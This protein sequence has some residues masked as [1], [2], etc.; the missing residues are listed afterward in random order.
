V[1]IVVT[2]LVVARLQVRGN[3][4]D[5]VW[6][7]DGKV[8]LA[9]AQQH[10]L[11]SMYYLYAGYLQTVSRALALAGQA[12]LPLHDYATYTVLA[13]ALVVGA[14]AAFVYV[15]AASVLG[16]A[17]WAALP[18]LGMALTPALAIASL[19][20][21]TD[22]QWY[23]IFAAFWAML[24]PAGTTRPYAAT[25][26]AGLAALTS[27]IAVLVAPAAVVA[28]G[29]KDALRSW[30]LRA[31][32]AGEVIQVIGIAVAPRSGGGPARAGISLHTVQPI[33]RNLFSGVL[34]PA[35]G[36]LPARL[37]AGVVIGA[38][39]VLAWWLVRQ[40]RRLASASVATGLLIYFVTCAITGQ[41]AGRYLA[42]TAMFMIA[43]LACLGPHLH[44]DAAVGA[45]ALVLL[46]FIVSF[47]AS[48]FRLSGPSWSAAVAQHETECRR[49][50]VAATD[51]LQSPDGW[52][53]RIAC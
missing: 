37:L 9:G 27:P 3:A 52:T 22:L 4:F 25:I 24:L 23:F 14:L 51:V 44:R 16:S 47:P 20:S 43:A 21:L 1:F 26:V 31:L 8:F 15:T 30:P 5:H 48:R 49:S 41:A 35:Y 2:A 7:E 13:S 6:G 50:R 12:L 19:G 34:G 10:G 28:N 32:L 45:L 46:L 18:A 36:P 33:V 39:L 38:L 29:R 17:T 11:A 40:G 53:T 42:V